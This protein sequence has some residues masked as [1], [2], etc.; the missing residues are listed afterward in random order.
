MAFVVVTGANRGIGAEVARQLSQQGHEVLGTTR[1]RLDLS[2]PASI[3]SFA[4][5]VETLD[6]LI[7]NAAVAFDGFDAKVAEDT[8]RVNVH[9]TVA[10]TEALLPKLQAGGR[11]VM[12][13][14]GMGELAGFRG[15][16]RYDL[17]SPLGRE[18]VLALADGF[19]RLVAQGAHT[20]HGWPSTAY[21]ASKALLGAYVRQLARGLAQDPRGLSVVAVC[22]GWVRTRMGGESAPRSV[23]EGAASV[24][25]AATSPSVQTGRFFRDGKLISW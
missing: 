5:S 24:V 13:S 8:L 6:V 18:G 19:V 3:V 9:G 12:V 1:Q 7:N 22:P 16:A 4:S 20:S 14:S 10:L 25:W 23:E 15:Q 11:I 21:G 2:D 17:E